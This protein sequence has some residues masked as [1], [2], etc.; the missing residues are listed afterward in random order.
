[1]SEGGQPQMSEVCGRMLQLFKVVERLLLLLRVLG[2]YHRCVRVWVNCYRCQDIGWMLQLCEG[3]VCYSC[4][5]ELGGGAVDILW[6]LWKI[7]EAV[8]ILGRLWEFFELCGH[9]FDI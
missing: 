3:M 7:G 1:M 2:E 9:F 5:K 6:K 4:L 8:D